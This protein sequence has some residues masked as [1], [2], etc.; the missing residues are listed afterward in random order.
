MDLNKQVDSKQSGKSKLT[1]TPLLSSLNIGLMSNDTKTLPPSAE[2]NL[3]ESISSAADSPAKM[4]L[5]LEPVPVSKGNDQ[6][7]GEKCTDSFAK[8]S[9]DG[10]WLKMY[11]GYFQVM[12]DSSLETFSETWPSAGTMRNGIAYPLPPLAPLIFVTAYSFWPTPEASLSHVGVYSGKTAQILM[13]GGK[14]R[15]SGA[16]IGSSLR[17][18]PRLFEDFKLAGSKAIPNPKF[19]EWLM[20]FPVDWTELNA[21]ETLSSPQLQKE[22]EK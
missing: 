7:Y 19:L 14:T 11:Q 8:L 12:L 6:H 21:S 10:Y 1:S 9:P 17:W 18:E 20:G 2:K 22:S 16:L 13:S 3:N 5:L 4:S 15:K